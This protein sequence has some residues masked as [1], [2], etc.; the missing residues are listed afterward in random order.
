MPPLADGLH[1]ALRQDR[2]ERFLRPSAGVQ[3]QGMTTYAPHV[4]AAL[5]EREREAWG[6]YSTTLRDLEGRDYEDAETEAWA[7]LQ[8]DLRA[9][10]A[11]RVNN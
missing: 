6:R 7:E 10:D 3:S 4:E 5:Q 2:R 9:I 1:G 8:R 11:E